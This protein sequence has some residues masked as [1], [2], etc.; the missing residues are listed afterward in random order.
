MITQHNDCFL[1]WAE[2]AR[3]QIASRRADS[4]EY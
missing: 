2:S 3:S 1:S 4:L